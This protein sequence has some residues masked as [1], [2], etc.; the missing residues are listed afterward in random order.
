MCVCVCVKD[1]FRLLT[2]IQLA[3]V[4]TPELIPG[5]TSLPHKHTHPGGL[6]NLDRTPVGVECGNA[7]MLMCTCLYAS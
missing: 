4:L 5:Q 2:G 7:M 6:F 3:A 1:I